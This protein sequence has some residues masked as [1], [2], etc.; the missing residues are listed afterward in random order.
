LNAD[1]GFLSDKLL[2]CRLFAKH[3]AAAEWYRTKRPSPSFASWISMF[4]KANNKPAGDRR[5]A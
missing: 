2:P 3:T 5:A 1:F 4:D